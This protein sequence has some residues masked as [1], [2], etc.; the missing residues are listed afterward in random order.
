MA[1]SDRIALLRNGALEQVAS[2]REIYARPATAYTAEFIGQTNLLRATVA[3]GVATWANL[4]W[5]TNAPDGA[6]TFSLRPETIRLAGENSA[7]PQAVQF[8]ATIRQQT[9]S[10]SSEH[11][12]LD[13]AGHLRRTSL[14]LLSFG[15]NPGPRGLNDDPYTQNCHPACPEPMRRDRSL[16]PASCGTAIRAC[17]D[18]R[19]RC[20]LGFLPPQ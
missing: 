4:R 19:R 2:P 13:C 20:A 17:P 18:P 5:P 9:F 12:E 1:L 15:R 6:I 14:F 11:L 7:P 3:H 10:G 16:G 8:R